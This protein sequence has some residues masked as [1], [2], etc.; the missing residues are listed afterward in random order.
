MSLLDYL[1]KISRISF[2][3]RFPTLS[4]ITQLEFVTSG[5]SM[6]AKIPNS[7]PDGTGSGWQTAASPLGH[8]HWR[9]MK[10][11]YKCFV[12]PQDCDQL[13]SGALI[14][15][16]SLGEYPGF[17]LHSWCGIRA[18]SSPCLQAELLQAQPSGKTSVFICPLSLWQWQFLVPF[19]RRKM[20]AIKY[21]T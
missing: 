16:Y 3:Y 13:V 2:L 7:G 11:Q 10:T 15:L 17:V 5:F 20:R 21:D 8:R 1:D 4:A 6:E 14:C 12:L 9:Q 18:A 19:H